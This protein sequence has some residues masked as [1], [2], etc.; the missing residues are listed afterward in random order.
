MSKFCREAEMTYFEMHEFHCPCCQ[1]AEMDE[2]FIQQL[3]HARKRADTPFHITSGYRCKAHNALVGGRPGSSHT[4][5]KAVDLQAADS[6]SRFN[7]M[8]GLSMAGFKRIGLD[9]K[10]GFIH[11]DSDG[12]KPQNVLW[13]Y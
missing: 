12:D 1:R 6:R 11:V 4:L 5:G 13:G 10:R 7:I 8:R 2:V 9:T 3:D